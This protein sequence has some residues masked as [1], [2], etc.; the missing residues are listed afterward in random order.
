[1]KNWCWILEQFW[2]S[3][4]FFRVSFQ[5]FKPKKKSHFLTKKKD[6]ESVTK[7]CIAVFRSFSFNCCIPQTFFLPLSANIFY[8]S[9]ALFS[10]L[11]FFSLSSFLSDQRLSKLTSA[12]ICSHRIISS[13][14]TTIFT[15]KTS[16]SFLL[17]ILLSSFSKPVS[18]WRYEPHL[19]KMTCSA[20]LK[21]SLVDFRNHR[22]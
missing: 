20:A 3:E 17:S 22:I 12:D 8:V 7:W 11:R 18:A 1:M 16:V 15:W 2:R 13:F 14:P 21:F 5:V 4:I 10:F 19:L 9:Y 6:F